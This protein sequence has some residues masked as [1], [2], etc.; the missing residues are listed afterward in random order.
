MQVIY[1]VFFSIVTAESGLVSNLVPNYSS[2]FTNIYDYFLNF[3]NLF[4]LSYLPSSYN[5]L[6]FLF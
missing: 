1:E 5:F 6:L 2:L 3:Y 4:L